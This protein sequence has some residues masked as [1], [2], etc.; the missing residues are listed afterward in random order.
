MSIRDRQPGTTALVLI[1]EDDEDIARLVEAL[2]NDRGA[3]A[4]RSSNGRD[5]IRAFF[6]QRPDLVIL[7]VGLPVMDGWQVLG[8]IREVSDVPVL[9]LTALDNEQDKVFGLKSGADDYMVK[10][11]GARELEARI[12]LLLRRPRPAAEIHHEQDREYSDG[13]LTVN[14]HAREVQ[15]LG[16]RIHLTTLEFNLL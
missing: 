8:R 3:I 10:P 14:W 15:V 13:D 4:V 1:V 5:A 11:F 9:M 7:D 2:V 12:E 6:E 16:K